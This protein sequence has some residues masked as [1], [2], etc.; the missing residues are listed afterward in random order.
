MIDKINLQLIYIV[1]HI[2]LESPRV[3]MCR[4]QPFEN[5]PLAHFRP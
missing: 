1:E 5:K 3:E 4:K 2:L